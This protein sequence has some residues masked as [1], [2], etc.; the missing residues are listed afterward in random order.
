MITKD[1]MYLKSKITKLSNEN[2]FLLKNTI[3]KNKI[4]INNNVTLNTTN[5]KIPNNIIINQSVDLKN[6]NKG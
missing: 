1:N 5:D 4:E 6:R 3:C 2:K